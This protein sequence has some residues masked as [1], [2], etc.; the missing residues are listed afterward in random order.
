M[1]KKFLALAA[2]LFL[3]FAPVSAAP[4]WT[5]PDSGVQLEGAAKK[6]YIAETLA[7]AY[8]PKNPN[9]SL[10]DLRVF[11]S[12]EKEI[13]KKEENELFTTFEGNGN[14]TVY[15]ILG[16]RTLDQDGRLELSCIDGNIDED[17]VSEI[18]IHQSAK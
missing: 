12:D 2:A 5:M 15:V 10:F 17:D 7:A 9:N 11:D 3:N 6:T 14:A 8:T 4:A 16:N 18:P 13:S 1:R